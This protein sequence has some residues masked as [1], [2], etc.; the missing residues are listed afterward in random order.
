MLIEAFQRLLTKLTKLLIDLS[1][2]GCCVF[3]QFSEI[4]SIV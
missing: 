4:S 1:T 2:L 3:G